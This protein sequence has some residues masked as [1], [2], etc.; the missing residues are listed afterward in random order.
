MAFNEKITLC[1]VKEGLGT[2]E[3]KVLDSADV[4]ADVT[5]MGVTTKYAAAAAGVSAE[6]QAVMYRRE[7]KG[8]THARYLGTLYQISSTGRAANDMH[9]KLILTR[10]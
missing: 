6:L 1:T 5:D 7:Y 4:W 9:I 2:N 3:P 10:G 8:Q